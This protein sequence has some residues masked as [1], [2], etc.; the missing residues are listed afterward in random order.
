MLLNLSYGL[1]HSLEGIVERLHVLQSRR[2]VSYSF[3]GA[4]RA[5]TYLA[6]S[7]DSAC[8]LGHRSSRRA[9]AGRLGTRW[10]RSGG[11]ALGVLVCSW[12]EALRLVVGVQTKREKRNEPSEM[13][14]GELAD[15]ARAF[16]I[17]S[18]EVG[19]T[20]HVE[21]GSG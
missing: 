14:E 16:R 15:A 6:R 17:K 13:K 8:A 12:R 20:S 11:V 21:D 19:S 9:H 2:R 10:R 4:T 3:V 1:F 5:L 7:F 18:R